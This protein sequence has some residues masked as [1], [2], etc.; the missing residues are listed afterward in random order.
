[1]D[2]LVNNDRSKPVV[3]YCGS[4]P[5]ADKAKRQLEAAGYT[6]VVNGGGYKDLR[7]KP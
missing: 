3:L 1:V 6:N 2:Q 4:G 5:R 7:P